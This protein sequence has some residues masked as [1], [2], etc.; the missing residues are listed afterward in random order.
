MRR[1]KDGRA[2]RGR[3]L[4]L[5]TPECATEELGA[6]PRPAGPA[7]RPLPP[8]GGGPRTSSLALPSRAGASPT[9]LTTPGNCRLQPR[10]GEPARSL[11]PASD[12]ARAAAASAC[13]SRNL[14]RRRGF[15]H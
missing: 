8:A 12:M 9:R 2:V 7:P 5:V 3:R 10:G 11:G 6:P 13:R 15:L 4:R 14:R 1:R